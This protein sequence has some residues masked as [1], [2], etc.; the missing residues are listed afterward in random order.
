MNNLSIVLCTYNEEKFIQKTLQKLI[1]EEIVKE[2]IIVD[3]NSKDNTINIIEKIK[4]N[5]IKLF[6]RKD[7][8]G[9]ASAFNLGIS[10]SNENHILRFDVDMYSEIDY[11]LF[12]FNKHPDKDCIIFSRYI[13]DGKDLRSGYRKYPSFIINKICNFLLSNK[14]KDYTSCIMIFK[15]NILK[16]MPIKNTSYANFI[17]EFIFL[18]I[19]KNKSYIE[20]PFEQ[21]K[22]TEDN[23]K[24]APNLFTFIKN[25][26][27]Y[28]LTIMKCLFIKILG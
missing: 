4:S 15:K 9:F 7:V 10:K 12:N 17:I 11:F 20:V 6:V 22:S 5:K 19:K 16:D 2:I 23:S 21:K 27:L 13:N 8:R 24:S 26:S 1:D 25:G 3:D 18:L 28:L 14:I